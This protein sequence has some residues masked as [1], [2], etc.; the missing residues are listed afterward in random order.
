MRDSKPLIWLLAVYILLQLLSLFTGSAIF[1]FAYLIAYIM[2]IFRESRIVY[3][4]ARNGGSYKKLLI[5]ILLFFIS[6]LILFLIYIPTL[7]LN[8]NINWKLKGEAEQDPMILQAYVPPIL[9]LLAML[10]LLIIL[11]VIRLTRKPN[12]H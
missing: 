10:I 11:G 8:P 2:A 1:L 3:F 9:F 12:Y 5:P 6:N 7:L 4:F